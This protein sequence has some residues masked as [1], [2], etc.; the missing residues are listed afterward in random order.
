MENTINNIASLNYKSN[1]FDLRKE[2]AQTPKFV[3]NIIKSQDFET[4]LNY[5]NKSENEFKLNSQKLLEVSKSL[6]KFQIEVEQKLKEI[7]KSQVELNLER[8][9]AIENLAISTQQLLNN[10][11][12]GLN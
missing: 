3:D 12:G 2:K 8:S 5:L 4:A 7:S 10:S 6:S 11:R 1:G 9:K